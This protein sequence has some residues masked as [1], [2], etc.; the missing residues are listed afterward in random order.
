MVPI[1]KF[2]FSIYNA[3]LLSKQFNDI[4]TSQA[5]FHI[6]IVQSSELVILDDHNFFWLDFQI[7]AI[8][9]GV[10]TSLS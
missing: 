1:L 9:N 4:N 10:L 2:T 6:Y 8:L 7:Q 3:L 5:N